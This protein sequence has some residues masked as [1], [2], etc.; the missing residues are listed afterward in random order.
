MIVTTSWIEYNYNKF[1]KLYFGNTLPNISFKTSNTKKA[2][3]YATYKY[4]FINGQ[5]DN[6]GCLAQELREI[7]PEIVH[8][9]ADGYLSIEESKL[10]Y[11]LMDEV[12]QLKADIKELKNK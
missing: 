4:D 5:K 12:K 10:V 1:N 8:E 7:C 6:I 3:G 9:G 11:L 2:W